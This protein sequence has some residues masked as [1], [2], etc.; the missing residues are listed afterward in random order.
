MNAHPQS[1][2]ITEEEYRA[3]EELSVDK[4]EWRDVALYAMEVGSYN[5]TT[6][7]G[8]VAYAAHTALRGKP[9]KVHPAAQRIKVESNGWEVYPDAVIFC[10]PWRFVGKGDSTLL[11][12]KVVFEVL[13]ETTQNYDH[14]CKFSLYKTIETFEEYVLIDQNRIW[15]DHY[16]R[17]G[18]DWFHSSYNERRDSLKLQSVGIE[19]ALDD[20]Y[21]ELELPEALFGFETVNEE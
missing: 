11:T 19:I 18:D 15:I 7:C 21:D 20:I 2:Y 10:P 14:Q 13:S 16:R 5:H 9:C 4:H 1:R 6:I 3:S 8:N 12:P 17:V